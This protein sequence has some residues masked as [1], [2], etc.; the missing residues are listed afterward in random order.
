MPGDSKEKIKLYFITGFLGA[1]KTTLLNNILRDLVNINRGVIVNEFGEINVDAE[2]IDLEN[3]QDTELKEISSGSI[4][5]SCLSASFVESILEYEDKPIDMLFV[6][7]SGMSRPNSLETILDE[8]HKQSDHAFDYR[9]MVCIID[10]Q[11]FLT[12][13]QS[14]RAV[15]EQIIYS[16]Y[17]IIN[18]IDEV[19]EEV[20]QKIVEKVNELNEEAEVYKT[21]YCMISNEIL[22]N[23]LFS[24]KQFEE[25]STAG[26]G[27]SKQPESIFIKISKQIKENELRDF[28]GDIIN[29]SYRIKGFVP[30]NDKKVTHVDCV[31]NSISISGVKNNLQETGLVIFTESKRKII[32][33]VKKYQHLLNG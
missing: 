23:D 16:D 15:K 18:K 1:G 29:G 22:L 3:N 14:V 13:L 9:G 6:E 19:E 28:L 2:V 12:V 8:V 11:N 27:D 32:D 31:G 20:I 17:I 33:R 21:N 25:L 24:H 4:F 7:S 5:C 26:D 10:A 30:R